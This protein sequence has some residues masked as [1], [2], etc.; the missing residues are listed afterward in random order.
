MQTAEPVRLV[1]WDLDETFWD[2]TLT[3][4]GITFRPETRDIVI[5]LARRGIVSAICS[6]NDFDQVRQVLTDHGVWNTFVFPS[7][8]WTPK[9]PRIAALIEAI[10]LRPAT[11]MFIDDNPSNLAEVRDMVPEIQVREHTFVPEILAHPLFKGKD[12]SALKRLQQYKLLEKRKADEVSAGTDVVQFLRDS[13]IRVELD[14]DI[15]GNLDRAV[16]LINRTNQLNFTKARLPDDPETARRE[17]RETIT[18][19][20]R[21]GAL[22]RVKDRY[23]DHGYCGIYIHCSE[24]RRLQHYAFSCRILGMGVERWL[25]NELGRPAIDVTGEVLSDLFVE[26]PAIDWINQAA[27]ARDAAAMGSGPRIT[28]RGG[29][30]LAA[31]MHYFA[32]TSHDAVCEYHLFRNGTAYRVEH[33]ALLPYLIDGLTPAQSE[34]AAAL[35][36]EPDDFKSRMFERTDGTQVVL[37]SF[38]TDAIFPLWRHRASGLTVPFLLRN[39]EEG[40]ARSL[41]TRHF[42]RDEY[43]AWALEKQQLLKDEYDYLGL[44]GEEAFKQNL[45]RLLRSLPGDTR[46]FIIEQNEKGIGAPQPIPLRTL[47]VNRW[48]REVCAQ[49]PNVTCI[50]TS[51]HVHDASDVGTEG[52]SHIHFSRLVYHRLYREIA[53]HLAAD[54]AA[55]TVRGS[56]RR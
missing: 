35:G 13:A 11:V 21:Q 55:S 40:D 5:E 25:Y 46:V 28:A 9:G 38:S 8:D 50:A 10:Q 17:L 19:Y 1:I 20:H 12:D 54:H 29:C 42:P 45:S 56:G 31:V 26:T 22:V 52:H 33:G 7:I 43:R 32:A 23:G 53:H 34:A 48:L 36:Y 18:A 16:E 47:A 2:G 37:L 4:G 27:E 49:W 44:I 14:F 30:D 3:E 15:E 6:K 24:E 51:K 39:A 41:A